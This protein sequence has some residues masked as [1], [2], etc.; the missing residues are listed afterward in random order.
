MKNPYGFGILLAGLAYLVFS[1]H[2][3]V[4][5]LLVESVT[6][7]QILFFRS[8]T[9]CIGCFL[10]G[11]RK[12]GHRAVT[13]DIVKPMA[14]RSLFLI[15]A[16]LS[17]Y[18]AAK[19]LQLGE[20]TT[21]YFAAPVV[22]TLLAGPML[23]EHVTAARWIA[24]IVGF[25]GVVVASN[26]VGLAISWPVYLALQAA[27]L[28]AFATVLL[29]RTALHESTMV[30]MLITNFFFI[31]L[32]AGMLMIE[33]TNVDLKTTAMLF[34]VGVL[35]G[36]AQFAYFEAMRRAPVSVLAPFEYT[37]LAWS[38]VLGFLIWGDKPAQNVIAGAIL[39]GGAGLLI[40]FGE[41]FTRKARS[42]KEGG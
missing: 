39:I 11:G 15:G 6:V 35:G 12:L 4:I 37:A 30:Q 32:T 10:I 31:L 34:G 38:F 1:T 27:C 14:V 24:V 36:L 41:R 20:L 40:I 26:P 29:R 28:W 16:W 5:K 42:V 9:V 19:S 7:W 18:S 3:A 23:K 13:S 25:I 8:V 22:A 2:D 33:W 17:Y 21:L